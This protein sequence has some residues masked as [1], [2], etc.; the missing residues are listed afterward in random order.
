[1]NNRFLRW[2]VSS[3]AI[4]LLLPW[5]AVTLVPSNAGMVALMTLFFL[6]DPIYSIFIGSAAGKNIEPMWIQPVLAA[7][8]FVAGA[9]I[10]FDMGNLSF[11]LYGFAYLIIG[12]ISMLISYFLSKK[13]NGSFST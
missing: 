1:M 11:L 3:A 4:M 5:L 13:Q 8:L 7:A 6:I 9:W 2:T 10:F 12:T